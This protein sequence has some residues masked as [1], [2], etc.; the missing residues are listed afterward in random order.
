MTHT[1]LCELHQVKDTLERCREKGVCRQK[2]AAAAKGDH[3][4]YITLYMDPLHP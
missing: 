3:M 4:R 1:S 2:R